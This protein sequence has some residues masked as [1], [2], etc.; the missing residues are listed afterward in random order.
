MQKI[1]LYYFSTIK[2]Y[3]SKYH[4]YIYT[5]LVRL[6][7]EEGI[8]IVHEIPISFCSSDFL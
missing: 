2:Y 6:R 4:I 1:Y 3:I 8:K 7:R 5:H